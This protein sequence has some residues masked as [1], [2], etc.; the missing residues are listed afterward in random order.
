MGRCKALLP[1]GGQTVLEHVIDLFRE[2]G[3]GHICVVTGFHRDRVHP[4]IEAE[5]VFEARNPNPEEGM[6]SSICTGIRTLHEQCRAMFLL[7]V[8]IPLVRSCA[9]RLLAKTW[10]D[11]TSSIVMP[12]CREESGH[13]P[14]VPS[15]LAASILGWTGDMGLHG[16]FGS[17][18]GRIV[19]VQVPDEHM[20]MDMDTPEAYERVLAAWQG[21]GVPSRTECLV[22]MEDVRPIPGNIRAHSL[23]VAGLARAM[24]EAL[25]RHGGTFDPDLLEA[26]GLLHDVAR[27]ERRHGPRGAEVLEAMG[28]GEVGRIIAPHSDMDIPQGAPMTHREIVFLAD[29]YFKGDR[30]VSLAARYGAKMEQY[31]T[32]PE[33]RAHVKARLDHALHSETRFQE[34]TGIVLEELARQVVGNI[35]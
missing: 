16:F 17:V 7:P 30:P 33:A 9:L 18:R 32:N 35:P 4:V 22:M 34:R 23:M 29:K 13:P 5:G 3:I 25:N 28:F 11:Q 12:Y 19:P 24:G 26:A 14:L 27:L 31:G 2:V 8:D 21:L 15:S 1:L 10:N 6:F 20:L